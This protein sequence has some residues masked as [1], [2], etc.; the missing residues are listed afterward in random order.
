MADGRPIHPLLRPQ[1]AGLLRQ[2]RAAAVMGLAGVAQIT[3]TRLH[4]VGMECPVPR[5][6]GVPCP[7]CGLTR[8]CVALLSGSGE[9]VH[10]HALAPMILL[11]TVLLLVAAVLPEQKRLALAAN[12]EHLERRTAAPALA[13]AVILLYWTARL[14]Y[15]PAAFKSLVLHH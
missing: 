5:L 3:L 4:I 1:F 12:V 9:W 14:I 7:G 10:L 15:A 11:A 2:R 13:L 6:F 8:A